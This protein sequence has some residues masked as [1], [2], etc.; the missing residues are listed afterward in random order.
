MTIR[1]PGFRTKRFL[2]LY[3]DHHHLGLSFRTETVSMAYI[4]KKKSYHISGQD[5]YPRVQAEAVR[6]LTKL[7]FQLIFIANSL[8]VI[9]FITQGIGSSIFFNAICSIYNTFGHCERTL[10]L[11]SDQD[12]E[13]YVLENCNLCCNCGPVFFKKGVL[14]RYLQVL[15]YSISSLDCMSDKNWKIELFLRGTYR[16]SSWQNETFVFLITKM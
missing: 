11:Y 14:Y 2:K 6:V 5:T 16:F 4:Q 13:M 15:L 9:H 8:I 3:L 1:R 10:N 12:I 7:R